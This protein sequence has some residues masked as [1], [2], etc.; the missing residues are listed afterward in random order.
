MEKFSWTDRVRNEVLHRGK[1]ETDILHAIKRR[2]ADCI[3]HVLRRNCV[4]EHVIEGKVDVMGRRGRRRKQLPEDL[5]E[6]K[7][8]RKVKEEALYRTVWRTRFGGG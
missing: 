1:E 3:R 4:L 6:K 2:K 8:Y 5:K 7:R